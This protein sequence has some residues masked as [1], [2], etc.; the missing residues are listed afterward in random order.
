MTIA[1][2]LPIITT[3]VMSQ[4]F[5]PERVD[6]LAPEAGGRL[7]AIT[8][9]PPR[10]SMTLTYNNMRFRQSDD[11]RAWLALLRGAQNLIFAF[12]IDRQLPRFH[13]GGRSFADTPASWTQTIDGSGVARLALTGLLPGQVVSPG[14]YVGFIWETSKLALVRACELVMADAA[15]AVAPFAIEPAVPTLVPDEATTTL[16]RAGC[17][18]RLVTGDTKLAEQGLGFTSTGSRIVA[19]QDYVA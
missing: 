8:A 15:G 14:D 12:D 3:G 18:M 11:L 2:P 10:W 1:F 19:V 17:L 7:G 9:G 16:R 6:Y 13:Q 4:M 5:E